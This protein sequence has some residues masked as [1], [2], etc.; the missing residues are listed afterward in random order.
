[1]QKSRINVNNSAVFLVEN[2]RVGWGV[3]IHPPD[4]MNLYV[5]ENQTWSSSWCWRKS[6]LVRFLLDVKR[7]HVDFNGALFAWFLLCIIYTPSDGPVP[8]VAGQSFWHGT[9][10][11]SFLIQRK[12]LFG[13]F[14]FYWSW[15]IMPLNLCKGFSISTVSVSGSI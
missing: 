3:R 11:V 15:N 12:V 9:A 1:M 13:H 10:A 7:K 14:F 5:T 4:N 6:C 2:H 8:P